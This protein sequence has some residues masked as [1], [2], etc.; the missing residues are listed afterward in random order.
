MTTP[1]PAPGSAYYDAYWDERPLERTRR[2]SR[3]R[4][5]LALDLLRG[6]LGEPRG[7]LLE[8]GCGPGFALEVFRD[9][10]LEARGVDLSSRAVELARER[11][12]AVDHLESGAGDLGQQGEHDLVVALEVLEHV[13]EPLELITSLRGCLKPG[14]LLVISLP[15]EWHLVSRLRILLG[16]PSLG[17]HDDPHLRHFSVSDQ[18]RLFEAAGLESLARDW[19]GLVPPSWPTLRPLGGFLA[20]S[21]PSMFALSG[22]HV[23]RPRPGGSDS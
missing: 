13:P 18:D 19:D 15:N 20:R 22:V 7:S 4:A 17:G 8:V 1:S 2:R 14:G 23:L 10:G 5:R 9:A 6:L 12:L 16:R 11:G 21:W 3:G